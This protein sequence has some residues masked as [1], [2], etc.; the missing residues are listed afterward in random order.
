[1]SRGIVFPVSGVLRYDSP[2]RNIGREDW[3]GGRS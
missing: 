2:P 3:Q 1:M